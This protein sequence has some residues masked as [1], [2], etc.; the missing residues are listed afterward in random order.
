VSL[1]L[2]DS[3]LLKLQLI[4]GGTGCV[5]DARLATDGK[6]IDKGKVALSHLQAGQWYHLAAC[7]NGE[8]GR[9]DIYLNGTLQEYLLPTN[10][11]HWKPPVAPTGELRLGGAGGNGDQAVRIA[12]DQLRVVDETFDATDLDQW[13]DG[14]GVAALAGEGRTEFDTGIDLDA[15]EKTL[16]FEADFSE[17]LQVIH[18][19]ELCTDGKRVRAAPADH[20]VLEG[21][22]KAWT[23]DRQLRVQTTGQENGGHLVL[24]S[25]VVAPEDFLLEWEVEPRNPRKGLCIIF[26][27]SRPHGDHDGSIHDVALPRRGGNFRDYTRGA[28][29]CYHCSY[30][31]THWR[32]PHPKRRTANL[33][34]NR[35]F[36]MVSC[37]SDLIWGKSGMR[38]MRLLKLGGAIRLEVDG[39]LALSFDDDGETYGSVLGDG[40]IGLRQMGHSDEIHY[41]SFRLYRAAAAE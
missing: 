14:R 3:P 27:A 39:R 7:W 21:A 16:L 4:E 5:L 20:W 23:E 25:P 18:E 17:E 33:R 15:I 41:G 24:W 29:D 37:G 40:F 6:P 31:A 38:Q 34:K 19:D 30:F 9:F 2:V 10:E 26:F 8:Q 12:V 22:G 35:G 1:P 32:A 36:S 11:H 28:L 13:L